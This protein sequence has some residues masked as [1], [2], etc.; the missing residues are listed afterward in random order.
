MV[1]AVPPLRPGSLHPSVRPSIA[2]DDLG[3]LDGGVFVL[4]EEAAHPA[5]AVA[6]DDVVGIDEV[7]DSGD[8]GDVSADHDGGLGG[9]AADDAAHVAHFADVDDDGGDAHDVV[10]VG[11][12][13]GFEDLAGGEIQDRG[14]GGDVLLDHEDAPGA[15]E[16]AEGKGTL[17]AGHLVVI[18]LHGVDLAAAELVVLSVGT[19]NRRKE[20]AGVGTFWMLLH[21]KTLSAE[22]KVLKTLSLYH[23]EA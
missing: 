14:G 6:L 5:D 11:L 2:G 22:Y 8:G 21:F 13:L 18:Q 15:V 4:A 12:Q 1:A 17:F 3:V 23:L 16:H 10:V 7:F 20:D 19:E 9:E